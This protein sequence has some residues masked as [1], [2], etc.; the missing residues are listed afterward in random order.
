LDP[1][2]KMLGRRKHSR[3]ALSEPIDG[4][5]RLREEVAI[6][7]GD[8]EVIVLSPEPLRP[9]EKLTLEIPGDPRR[10]VS[11]KV[12]ESKPAITGDGAIRHRL[13]LSIEGHG[14]GLVH[15]GGSEP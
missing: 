2:L 9:D 14:I 5:L 1:D 15:S 3:F 7:Q 6:E 11:V 13:R 10:R 12:S 8:R 4:S